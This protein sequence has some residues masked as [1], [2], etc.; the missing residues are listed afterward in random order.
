MRLK[1]MLLL[2]LIAAIWMLPVSVHAEAII[3][4]TKPG[5]VIGKA[6]RSVTKLFI[7]EVQIPAM[8]FNGRLVV[9][10][11]DLKNYGFV[12]GWDGE[13]RGITVQRDLGVKKFTKAKDTTSTK[14]VNVTYTDIKVFLDNRM[15]PSFHIDKKTAIYADDI[16]RYGAISYDTKNKAQRLTLSKYPLKEVA[17][18]Y[19]TYTGGEELLFTN[20]YKED[21]LSVDYNVYFHNRVTQKIE[22]IPMQL[23]YLEATDKDLYIHT[24]YMTYFEENNIGKYILLGAAIESVKDHNGKVIKNPM[25][26]DEAKYIKTK[27]S[28][29]VLMLEKIRKS[30]LAAELKANKNVPVKVT[31]I[32]MYENS[33]GIPEPNI[34]FK[35]L[36]TKTIDAIEI[37]IRCFD[38]F[39]RAVTFPGQS[40]LFE[41]IVQDVMIPPGG[42]EAFSWTLNLFGN[43]TKINVTVVNVHFTDGT[44][45][46]KK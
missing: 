21:L 19:K 35:N 45:W 8:S 32:D 24:P 20:K 2:V 38:T 3:P 34:N 15:V 18:G 41:G 12:P 16:F 1:K 33:I 23:S 30:A 40:N 13:Y 42:E 11:S 36:S 6:Q 31:K 5:L 27:Y 10:T 17:V 37:D 29:Y 9:F 14:E 22:T 7:N 46:K 43:T 25:F 39:G 26:N 28:D 4:E 44:T